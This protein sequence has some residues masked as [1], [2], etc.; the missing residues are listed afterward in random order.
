[1]NQQVP[2]VKSETSTVYVDVN[3][4]SYPLGDGKCASDERHIELIWLAAQVPLSIGYSD[5]LNSSTAVLYPEPWVASILAAHFS[6]TLLSWTSGPDSQKN[7][8]IAGRETA[9]G[10]FHH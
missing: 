4:K 9:Q 10:G 7:K 8:L 2:W 1:M 6:P 5:P 3:M